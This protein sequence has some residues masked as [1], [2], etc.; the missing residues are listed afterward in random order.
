MTEKKTTHGMTHTRIYN[1]WHGML[2]RC[3]NPNSTGFNESYGGRGITVCNRWRTF[4]LFFEDMGPGKMG[5]K[6]ERVNN[7]AG[8]TL[9]NC[10]WATPKRQAQN[11]RDNRIV[12]VQGVTGCL[13]ELCE[14]FHVIYSRVRDR[15]ER[16]WDVESAFF[17]PKRINQYA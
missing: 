12:T 6:V 10:V 14:R 17:T 3:L 16:G 8:Y 1:I 11:R 5:W 15:L 9:E 4:E 2:Q 7:D 13:K